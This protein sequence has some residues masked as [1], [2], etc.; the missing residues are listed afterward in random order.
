MS[1]I[2][3]IILSIFT[4]QLSAQQLEGKWK[5]SK[6][7]LL[8]MGIGYASINGKCHF[9]N[10]GTFTFVIKGRSLLGHK[11]WKYRTMYAKAKGHYIIN[12]KGFSTRISDIKVNVEPEMDNPE[13]DPKELEKRKI[14]TWDAASTRYENI[15]IN[16]EVQ[17]QT[18]K[19]RI[20]NLWTCRNIPIYYPS[21]KSINIGSIIDLRK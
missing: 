16:C 18:I 10:D 11:F 19:E 17:E 2:F 15:R 9:K 1:I 12:S 8:N 14:T 13:F 21:K 7:M 5:C 20:L 4:L 6:E 3:I